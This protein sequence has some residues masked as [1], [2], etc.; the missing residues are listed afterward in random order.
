MIRMA[1]IYDIDSLVELR[2]K[3]LYESG[4]NIE[5]YDWDKYSQALRKFFYDG[6]LHGTVIAF[7][8]EKDGNIVSISIMCFYNIIPLLY[9][10]EGKMALL[11]DMYTIPEYR[12][13]GLGIS[14]LNDI[15]GHAKTLGYK[16]VVLNAT[17][18]GR[19]LYA[20]YG[21]ED[22]NGE[23]SYKFK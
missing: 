23:M 12:N 6:L 19:R 10:L 5:N 9:N 1:T 2:I 22:I 11:T 3:L 17:D 13:K 18:S 20:K 21:F 15:M 14:L 7:L 8:V 16:K 4:K